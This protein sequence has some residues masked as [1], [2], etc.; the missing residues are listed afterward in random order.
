MRQ[1]F[2]MWGGKRSVAISLRS[3][4]QTD[5]DDNKFLVKDVS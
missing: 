3:W 1:Y 2:G 4:T 5:A